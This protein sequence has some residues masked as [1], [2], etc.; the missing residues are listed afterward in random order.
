MTVPASPRFSLA[1]WNWRTYL[2]KTKDGLK[3]VLGLLVAYLTVVIAPIEPPELRN[4]LAAILGYGSKVA[5]D[6][7]DYW[8]TE[9]PQ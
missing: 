2:A 4:L 6:V 5:A 9:G 3:W 8:L 1:G 7:V